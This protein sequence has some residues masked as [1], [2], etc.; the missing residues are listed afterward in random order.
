MSGNGVSMPLRY[1]PTPPFFAAGA[2][3]TAPITVSFFTTPVNPMYAAC[4]VSQP[5]FPGSPLTAI[6]LTPT[7]S[8]AWDGTLTGSQP[9]GAPP[10]LV[11]TRPDATDNESGVANY[12]YHATTSPTDTTFSDSWTAIGGRNPTLT[13]SGGPLDYVNQFFVVLV[14]QNS[15]GGVSKPL[16]YGPFR[17]SDPT[18]PS[19]PAFCAT[20]GPLPGQL[21]ALMTI[22]SVDSETS[23]A[24]YQYHI[25]TTKGVEVRPWPTGARTDWPASGMAYVAAGALTD[26]Q[27]YLVDVRAVNR[28]GEISPFATSGAVLYDASAPPNPGVS[29]SVNGGVATMTATAAT[30]PQSGLSAVQWAVGTTMSTADVVPWSTYPVGAGG[31][32]VNATL[33]STLPIGTT[34]YVQARSVN[35]A[36]VPSTISVT[37]FAVPLAKPTS[38]TGLPTLPPPGTKVP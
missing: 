9:G 5:M 38:P 11:L 14:A 28:Q 15:A 34:L 7:V 37:S 8:T 16:V 30:D 10:R 31:G 21:A 23:V 20:P 6:T 1:D 18:P 12:Y 32:N 4:P 26:G 17:V 13:V 22:P 24:G 19:I 33:P 25:R 3:L 36:G 29:V 2:A 27:S 35:L